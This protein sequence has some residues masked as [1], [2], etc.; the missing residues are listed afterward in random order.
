MEKNRLPVGKDNKDWK[1]LER[2]MRAYQADPEPESSAIQKSIKKISDNWIVLSLTLIVLTAGSYDVFARPFAEPTIMVTD[3]DP[4]SPFIFPFAV[5]NKSPILAMT[6]LVWRCGIIKMRS[7]GMTVTNSDLVINF[8][9]AD[10]PA[11]APPENFRC[12]IA[13]EGMPI[14]E[15]SMEVEMNYSSLGFS[16]HVHKQYYWKLDGFKSHW[17]EGAGEH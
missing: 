10:I 7:G 8:P 16:R 14:S 15:L 13:P 17:I 9:H 3:S 6:H 12:P 5:T 11:G 1:K 4:V 2:A